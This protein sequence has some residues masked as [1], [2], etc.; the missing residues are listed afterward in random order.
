[1][2]DDYGFYGKGF[3]GYGHYMTALDNDKGGGG[4]KPPKGEPGERCPHIGILY[5]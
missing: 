2:S 4:W 1:M 5:P 3:E